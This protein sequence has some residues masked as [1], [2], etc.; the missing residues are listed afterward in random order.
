MIDSIGQNISNKINKLTLWSVILYRDKYLYNVKN[1]YHKNNVKM[2]TFV[3]NIKT[4][5][6][7]ILLSCTSRMIISIRYWNNKKRAI[8]KDNQNKRKSLPGRCIKIHYL[9]TSIFLQKH[10]FIRKY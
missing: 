4:K 1:I 8:T 10:I 6:F 7:L 5:N 3:S 2:Y 9:E